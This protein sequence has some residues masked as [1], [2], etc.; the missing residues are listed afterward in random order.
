MFCLKSSTQFVLTCASPQKPFGS[1]RYWL[2][3]CER[4]FR[5]G[6]G[7]GGRLDLEGWIVGVESSIR[8][9]RTLRRASTALTLEGFTPRSVK[10]Y[11][12]VSSWHG[13]LF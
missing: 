9:D 8:F 5:G 10:A 1:L 12:K 4:G 11:L 13:V 7:G 2:E 6:R 3:F